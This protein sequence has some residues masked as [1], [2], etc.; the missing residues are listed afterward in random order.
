VIDFQKSRKDIEK[1]H[2]KVAQ[3][4]GRKKVV[5]LIDLEDVL[6]IRSRLPKI[7]FNQ[8]LTLKRHT[9][10]NSHQQNIGIFQ[11][12]SFFEKDLFLTLTFLIPIFL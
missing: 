10:V 11:K 1:F 6:K 5:T 9:G 8:T 12:R 7:F 2:I 4:L 3:L